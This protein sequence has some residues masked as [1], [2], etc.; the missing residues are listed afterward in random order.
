MFVTEERPN[1]LP[2]HRNWW[3][4]R[5]QGAAAGATYI[6]QHRTPAEPPCCVDRA[7]WKPQKHTHT[8]NK[9]GYSYS[10]LDQNKI[11]LIEKKQKKHELLWIT[12][13]QERKSRDVYFPVTK[14][15]MSMWG[16]FVHLLSELLCVC[17]Y[18]NSWF[19]QSRTSVEALTRFSIHM[20]WWR[21]YCGVSLS[22][23]SCLCRKK[24]ILTFQSIYPALSVENT[25][26]CGRGDN[27]LGEG[28][29]ELP[30]LFELNITRCK[31]K[32]P[33]HIVMVTLLMTRFCKK[34]LF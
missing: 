16:V 24:D 23:C 25:G 8:H 22:P 9:Q 4:G 33:S 17:A 10:N 32:Q 30:P 15:I 31:D 34:T 21:P 26:T 2:L 27:A 7:I 13:N 29:T 18:R 1:E 14:A 3:R 20:Q 19:L 6:E 12:T 28:T 5:I 11:L